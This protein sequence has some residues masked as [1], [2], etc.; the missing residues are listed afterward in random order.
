MW[1]RGNEPGLHGTQW[2]LG[3]A[4]LGAKCKCCQ[5][6]WHA[7]RAWNCAFSS[8][9]LAFCENSPSRVTGSR[10]A[11]L[12][13]ARTVRLSVEQLGKRHVWSLCGLGWDILQREEQCWHYAGVSFHD[14]SCPSSGRQTSC[15][16][17]WTATLQRGEGEILSSKRGAKVILSSTKYIMEACIGKKRIWLSANDNACLSNICSEGLT[18]CWVYSMIQ[19]A[20]H[21]KRCRWTTLGNMLPRLWVHLGSQHL[22]SVWSESGNNPQK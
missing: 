19:T 20:G 11:H 22:F 7:Q 5:S 2:L 18:H 16:G 15:S 4:Q 17:T 13:W 9:S 1:Q 14:F 6:V 10:P 12:D 3:S 8:L 21:L